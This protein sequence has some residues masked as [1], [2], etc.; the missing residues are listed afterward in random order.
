MMIISKQIPPGLLSTIRQ[1]AKAAELNGRSHIRQPGDRQEKL[2]QDNM[3][4]QVADAAFHVYLMGHGMEW[5]RKRWYQN[6]YPW[7]GDGGSDV[8]PSNI[9]VKGSLRHGGL[10]FDAYRL[11]VRPAELHA[12]TVYVLAIVEQDYS[13]CHFLGWASTAMLPADVESDG[14]FAGA[15]IL[16]ASKLYPLPPIVWNWAG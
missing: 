4:G 10:P 14:T 1:M 13:W 8:P 16:Q 5:K 7:Q 3:I 9:D 2:S 12:D 15:Y 11:A 6:H